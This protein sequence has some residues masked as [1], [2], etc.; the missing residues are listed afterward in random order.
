MTGA[1]LPRAV[2]ILSGGQSGVD[3][4]ALAVAA[5][6]GLAYGGWCPAGGWAEDMTEPPGVRALYP[7]LRESASAD[8]AERTVLNVRDAD[9][10]LVVVCAGAA[11]PGTRLTQR[12]ATRL[13]RPCGVIPLEVD[14]PLRPLSGARETFA[15]LM[16]EAAGEQP[17]LDIAGPRES[18]APGVEAAAAVLLRALLAPVRPS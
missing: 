2:R 8:P 16:G 14:G 9:A 18:E 11:S 17:A 4:A 6:L 5:E 13:G 12:A 1:G 7:L 10:V 15:R 3:R